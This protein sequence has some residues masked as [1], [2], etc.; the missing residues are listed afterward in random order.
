M[1][2]AETWA[3]A[4]RRARQLHP[5]RIAA[6]ITATADTGIR[7]TRYDAIGG[8]TTR[9]PCPEHETCEDGPEEHSHRVTSDPTGNA[10]ARGLR[11]DDAAQ[12]LAQLRRARADFVLASGVVL[13]WVCG[14]R[15]AT[16]TEVL[17]ADAELMPG[18][19]QAG[20]DVD[21]AHRLPRAIASVSAAVRTVASLAADH[22]PRTPSQDEQHWTAG[23]AD[24]DCCA[25]HLAI[26]RRYRRPRAAGKN[27][28]ADCVQLVLAGDGARPPQWLLEAEVDRLGKPRVWQVALGRWLDELGVARERS[29]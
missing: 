18:T 9:Q 27:I 23:L 14:K 10:A 25:W 5:D 13:D 15:P 8:R 24:E 11:G 2:H 22:E 4:M 28:C 21:H 16:W 3:D 29:A 19:V 26:H 1:S 20:L 17:H 6:R 7:A 12:D